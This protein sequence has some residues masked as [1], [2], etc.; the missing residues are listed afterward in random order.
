M[1]KEQVT[2]KIGQVDLKEK[3]TELLELKKN[4]I[5]KLETS[6]DTQLRKELGKL[7]NDTEEITQNAIQRNSSVENR[8]TIKKQIFIFQEDTTLRFIGILAK[9]NDDRVQAIFK[10]ITEDFLESRKDR[11]FQI[12]G[13]QGIPNK[14]N[15]KKS[16]PTYFIMKINET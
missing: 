1:V 3:H 2:I 12:Q 10:D 13:A 6:M 5:M 7:E 16:I 14:I 15:N 11:N 4:V 9:E 8:K